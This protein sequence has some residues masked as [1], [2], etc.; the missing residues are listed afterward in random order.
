MKIVCHDIL[1]L[2]S[3]Y[4][5]FRNGHRFLNEG[6]PFHNRTYKYEHKIGT[7]HQIFEEILCGP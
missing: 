5:E 1:C 2:C 4:E 6:L 3:R 7:I